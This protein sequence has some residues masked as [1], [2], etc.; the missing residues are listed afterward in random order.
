MPT[1]LSF[2]DSSRLLDKIL[3]LGCFDMGPKAHDSPD[4]VSFPDEQSEQVCLCELNFSRLDFILTRTSSV[5]WTWVASLCS[6]YEVLNKIS[7]S[8]SLAGSLSTGS[9]DG[10]RPFLRSFSDGQPLHGLHPLM[11]MHIHISI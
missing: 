9:P 5:L 2:C 7:A 8:S 11:I 4:N 10:H 6:V 3:S 1:C